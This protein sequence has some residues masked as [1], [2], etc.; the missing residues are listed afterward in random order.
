MGGS[1]STSA[2]Q[3][4]LKYYKQNREFLLDEQETDF[5][6][7]NLISEINFLP[8]PDCPGNNGLATPNTTWKELLP[9]WTN[10]VRKRFKNSLEHR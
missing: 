1:V 6:F 7:T 3:I 9:E 10:D 8:L 2:K 4:F 5:M